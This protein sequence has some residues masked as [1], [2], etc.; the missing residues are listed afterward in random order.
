MIGD[1]ESALELLTLDHSLELDLLLGFSHSLLRGTE[2]RALPAE[3]GGRGMGGCRLREPS[4]RFPSSFSLH[5]A[6]DTYDVEGLDP[7]IR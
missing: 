4:Y 5:P 3:C 2:P 6:L 1:S 7:E